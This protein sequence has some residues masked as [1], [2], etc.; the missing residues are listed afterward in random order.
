MKTQVATIT[1]ESGSFGWDFIIRNN[2]TDET[3]L[4]Q[5]DWD[6]PGIAQSFDLWSPPSGATDGTIDCPETGKTASEMIAEARKALSNGEGTT[7]EDP[8]YFNS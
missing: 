8:G 2:E 6:Y 7:V 4:V 1:L 3:I 5:T